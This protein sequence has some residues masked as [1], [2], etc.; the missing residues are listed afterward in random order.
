[1]TFQ[2]A[3]P[4]AKY[5]LESKAAVFYRALMDSLQSIPG[6]RS[7]GV[8]SGIPFGAGNYTT[9]P[10]LTAGSS[11][12]PAAAAVPIDWRVV[13]PGLFQNDVDSN[14]PR[15]RLH[16]CRWTE[17]RRHHRQ[18]EHCEKVLGR[19]RPHRTSIESRGRQTSFHGHRHRRRRAEYRAEP[20][21]AGRV[22]SDG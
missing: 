10:M 5:S 13:Q 15:P 3:P 14:A 11:V 4:A 6:V 9:T 1:I 21:I 18:P 17:C 12:L 7:A 19:R 20:G 8:S 2:L 22:L 16:R